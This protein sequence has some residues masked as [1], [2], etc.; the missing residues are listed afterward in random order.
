MPPI[1]RIPPSLLCLLVILILAPFTTHAG[2]HLTDTDTTAIDAWF[3]KIRD[4]EAAL[5]AF[6]S[7]MPKGGDLHN[8]FTGALYA[9]SYLE[10]AIDQKLWINPKT[11]KL[12]SNP[13]KLTGDYQRIDSLSRTEGFPALQQRLFQDWSVKDYFNAL[14]PSDQHF[15]D[16]FAK[17]PKFAGWNDIKKGLLELKYRA[18]TENV[19]YLEI[20]LASVPYKKG[21]SKYDEPLRRA[22]REKDPDNLNSI[23]QVLF[24]DFARST[25][26]SAR[27]LADSIDKIHQGIDDHDFT[28]R[29]LCFAKRETLP[30]EVFQ[31]ILG[32]FKAALRD[33]LIGGVN[34]VAP[35]NGTLSLKDYALQMQM[36]R[37]LHARYPS[38]NISLH[39]GELTLGLV[40]PED[41]TWHIND[42]VYVGS[43][44][45]IGHGVDLPY[46]RNN[47]SLL[48]YMSR[49]KIAV[50]INLVSNQFI[51]KVQDDRHPVMLYAGHKVPIVISTDDAGI[52][53]TNLT[54]QFVTLAKRY[55]SLHYADIKQFIRNSIQYSFIKDPALKQQLADDVNNKLFVFEEKILKS[56]G[57][58]E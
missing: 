33:P 53:R 52:L 22:A 4:N 7:E 27:A 28:M 43:A 57:A 2:S 10:A 50:E 58:Y 32:A 41:L 8:H 5:T 21:A 19:Q 46:E 13:K 31:G 38:V 49:H 16:A 39:A 56:A 20:M 12:E 54:A 36:F 23:L 11:L 40:K 1:K 3:E 45:R 14:A 34:F 18:K 44:Q 47:D 35:E 55:R 17:F 24:N 48:R 6:F 42:A 30:V 25:D 9:E 51:L 26:D 15:F 29:Y 37:F